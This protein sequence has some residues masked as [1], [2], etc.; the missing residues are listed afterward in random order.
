MQ[1][2]KA[3]P[4]QLLT[5]PFTNAMAKKHGV[6]ARMLTGKRF[7][8]L[9]P[10]VH[11]AASY[12]MSHDDWVAAAALAL[13]TDA[14]LTGISRIQKTGLD[15]GPHFPVRFVVARDHHIDLDGI[16][17]HRT[18]RMPACDHDGVTLAAAFIAYCA[19][20]RVIDAVKVGDWLLHH[21]LMTG[22]EVQRLALTD[23]WR[24]GSHEA[25]WV[26]PHLDGDARSLPESEM[27]ALLTFA[28]LP[29]PDVNRLLQL[30]EGVVVMS[31]L[32]YA[33]WRTL[34]EYEG[35]QHQEDRTQ[36]TDDIAR[37]AVMRRN[38]MHYV[39]VTKE[40]LRRPRRVVTEVHEELVA[41]GYDGPAPSFGTQWSLLFA[42]LS[43]AVGPR[44]H[45]ALTA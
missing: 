8:R 25:I 40:T 21:G 41:A 12:E 38:E 28:G 43:V 4:D 24:P 7:V 22:E 30:D 19:L 31:D 14:Q 3:I 11:R 37:Y 10:R 17:L 13:P 18:K 44:T 5:G 27:R 33:K 35:G 23:L 2:M 29:R 9:Y 26:L 6:S 34:I 42:S 16:F 39:Q 15:Y 45:P 36:Y 32:L 20:A 1:G